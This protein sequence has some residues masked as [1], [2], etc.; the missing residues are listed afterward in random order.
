MVAGVHHQAVRNKHQ[1]ELAAL[2]DAG[3]LLDHR[4]LVV[5]GGGSVVSP[6]GTVIA[7]AEHENAEVHLTVANG[8]CALLWSRSPGL[9]PGL[10]LLP[11]SC[12]S[13]PVIRR[14]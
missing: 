6:T 9:I 4:Q 14:K 12:Y 8:H 13:R 5:A 7:G 3:D 11:G 2:G 10:F 1:V